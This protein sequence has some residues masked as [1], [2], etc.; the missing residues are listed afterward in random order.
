MSKSLPRPRYFPSL[1][2]VEERLAE[3]LPSYMVPTVFFSM[4]EL[5]MTATGKTD[6]KTATR[7]RRVVLCPAAG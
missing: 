1:P 4:R 3:Q 2:D 5:P 7:D 6:R